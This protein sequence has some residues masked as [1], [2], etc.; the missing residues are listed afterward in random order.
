MTVWTL[1]LRTR[2]F[3]WKGA[4]EGGGLESEKGSGG[5]KEGG[6]CRGAGEEAWR[7]AEWC[8]HATTHCIV[9]SRSG[10]FFFYFLG[11]ETQA[12]WLLTDKSAL[13]ALV[14]L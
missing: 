1:L 6:R 14:R 9:Q 12:T 2:G 8:T 13:P 5:G 11:F 10:L 3:G 7:R 4:G